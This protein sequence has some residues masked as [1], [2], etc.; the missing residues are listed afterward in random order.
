MKYEIKILGTK[1]SSSGADCMGAENEKQLEEIL[2]AIK[3]GG[4]YG[5]LVIFKEEVIDDD[6]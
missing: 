4:N 6:F 2:K 3:N 1:Y 5:A